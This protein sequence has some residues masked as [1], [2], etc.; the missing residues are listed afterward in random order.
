LQ[1]T[2]N[3]RRKPPIIYEN[4]LRTI[5][6]FGDYQNH[7]ADGSLSSVEF[8]QRKGSVTLIFVSEAD[9]KSFQNKIMM[10]QKQKDAPKLKI[11]KNAVILTVEVQK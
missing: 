11:N 7:I 2:V 1:E 10:L 5:S 8:D 9:A 4:Q 6:V 3:A